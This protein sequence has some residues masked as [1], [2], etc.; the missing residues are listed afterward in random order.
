MSAGR[1]DHCLKDGLASLY[2]ADKKSSPSGDEMRKALH[3][4][5]RVAMMMVTDHADALRLRSRR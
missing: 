1:S 2:D 5:I 4:D 3:A